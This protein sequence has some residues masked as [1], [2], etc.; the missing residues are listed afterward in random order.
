MVQ[1]QL[2]VRFHCSKS[3]SCYLKDDFSLGYLNRN[4]TKTMPHILAIGFQEICDLTA[5]NMVSA[6]SANAERWV[7]NVQDHFKC[8]HSKDEYILLEN[9]QLVGVCLA[10]FVRRDIAP[11]IK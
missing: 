9:D 2:L 11:F 10:L 4:Y 1:Y 8:A 6:S 7:R 3:N 5:S